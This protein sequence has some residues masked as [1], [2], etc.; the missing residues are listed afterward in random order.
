MIRLFEIVLFI[1]IKL[2]C[3][4]VSCTLVGCVVRVNQYTCQELTVIFQSNCTLSSVHY[5]GQV[6]YWISKDVP[7]FENLP[8]LASV[9]VE[10]TYQ[11]GAIKLIKRVSG[12]IRRES[13]THAAPRVEWTGLTTFARRNKTCDFRKLIRVICFWILWSYKNFWN[14]NYC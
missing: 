7:I 4:N 9:S 11:G 3:D 1:L 12:I 5:V 2:F 10:A 6:P 13:N 14:L 8:W